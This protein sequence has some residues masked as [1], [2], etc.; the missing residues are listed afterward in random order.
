MMEFSKKQKIAEV[1]FFKM[2]YHSL[3]ESEYLSINLEDEIV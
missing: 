3:L 1:L 2:R